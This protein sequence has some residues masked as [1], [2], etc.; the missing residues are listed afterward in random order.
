MTTGPSSSLSPYLLGAEPNVHFTSIISVGDA[1]PGSTTGVFGGIPDGM[2]AFDN[3]DGTFTVILNHEYNSSLGTVHDHGSI[4]AYIDRLV[5][6]KATLSVVSGDDAM[7]TLH[8]WDDANDTYVTGTT[9][10]S[11]F[12]SADLA[13]PTA[14]Y[15][16]ATGLGTQ[17]RIYLTG[18]ESGLEGRAVGTIVSGANSGNAYELPFLGNLA[19]ENVTANP[20]AQTKTIIAATDDGTNG[21]VYIYVG[22]KQATG[23]DIDMA[24]L[25]NGLFYGIKVAGMADETNASAVTGTFTL[26]AIGATGDVSNMT[27]AEIDADSEAKDVTSFLRPEDSAWDPDNPNTLYFTT[28]NSFTGNSR[29]YKA[30]FNDITNPEAGGTIEAVLDGS[31]GQHM[32]D[33]LTVA[34]GK[35]ILQEDPG[36]Q[37]YVAKVWEYDIATDTLNQVAGFNPAQFMPGAAGFITQDEESSGVIDVTSILGSATTRAYLLDAQVHQGTGDPATVEMGQLLV[38]YV[39]EA[40]TT[41]TKADDILNGSYADETFLGKDGNDIINA[42]SGNDTVKAGSGDDQVN[43]GAGDDRVDGGKGDDHLFGGDGNDYLTGGDGDDVIQGGLGR[44]G[45]VGGKGAD[46]FVFT[47]I[48]ES[49]V[50]KNADFIKDFSSAQGDRIDLS[51]IDAVAGG[52]DDA[53][54]LVS[55]FSG[56]A[57]ELTIAYNAKVG[58]AYVLGDV[59]GDGKADFQINLHHVAANSLSASDFVL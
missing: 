5:I 34:N 24:G 56:T 21:Q 20:L 16:A 52:S 27:G 33:N 48:A 41:G 10:F 19:Y 2:G 23:S 25:T 18:E 32:F 38:M 57:G 42:G 39:D 44:D 43:A 29:L 46:I 59:D 51:G 30:T 9:A 6:D 28:T 58:A 4:G 13:A 17:A 11:R 55:K 3:G 35:V 14:F 37:S 53:F 31:E 49:P 12:C 8:L 40:N 26:E 50:G 47:D 1:L 22:E 7:Q 15:D 36:N 45:M 54:T